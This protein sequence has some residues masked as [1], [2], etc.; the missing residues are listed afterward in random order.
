MK[1]KILVTGGC[2]YIGSHTIVDLIESGYEVVSLDNNI[3]S[4]EKVLDGIQEITGISVT[5][6]QVDLTDKEATIAAFQAHR[7]AIGVIH[8]AAYKSVK[9]SVESPLMY[10][11]NNLGSLVNV[12]EGLQYLSA[13]IFVFS[14]SCSVYGNVDSLPVTEDAPRGMVESPYAMTKKM[15]EDIIADYV[16]A[17]DDIKCCL[18][19][20]FNP[21][22]AHDSNKI[23]EVP[24]GAPDNVIPVIVEAAAGVRSQMHVFGDDYDTPDG[25]CI[26]DYIHIQDLASAHTHSLAYLQRL[27][28]NSALEVFNIGTGKG[29]SV[30]E[31][32]HAFETVN[33]VKVPCTVGPRR[34]G[35]I[36]AIYANAD[37][38]KQQLNWTE[39]RTTQDIMRS[40]WNWYHKMIKE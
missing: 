38:A 35:D 40:A 32:I 31:L 33:G 34:Q 10:Y 29:T 39:K 13:K 4:S 14:S 17:H 18:L 27:S 37:R 1:Q 15:G 22:G 30:F 36:V 24:I 26:R 20:Y 16:K 7:D 11:R 19:R 21:G 12:L 3:R 9:E 6:I 8:F 23:G 25:S 2:G 5:N 28:A